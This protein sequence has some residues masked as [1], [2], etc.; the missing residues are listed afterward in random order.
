[1]NDLYVDAVALRELGQ[2][3]LAI[4]KLRSVLAAD[5]KFALAYVELGKAHQALHDPN[6]A[7]AAF[8][9]A[10]QLA[11]WS[12]QN[13][14]HLAG[15]RKALAQYRPAAEAYARAAELDPKNIEA[16]CGAAQCYLEAGEPTKSLIYCELAEKAGERPEESLSLLARA[17]EAQK[18]Y[19]QAIGAYRR[20]LALEGEDPNVLRPL[21]VTYMKAG[22]YGRAREVLT[23]VAQRRPEDGP[24][25]RALG[26]CCLRLGDVE[27]AREVYQRAIEL[28]SR[29]WEAQR[30]LG[31]ACMLMARRTGETRWQDEALRH[32]RRALVLK[33]D[34]PKRETLEKL[35]REHAS[36]QNSLEGL[37]Y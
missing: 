13:Q 31:V 8:E 19:E 17:Y 10:A 22:Q 3:E 12:A 36:V 6:K 18:D 30:G 1:V 33:P 23:L 16:L 37:D 29:D 21:G 4:A 2:N 35:I 24:V 26:Y 32:W 28:D 34:Q 5:P 27:Q 14:L 20:L 9:R 11:P 7:L 25:F 15:T